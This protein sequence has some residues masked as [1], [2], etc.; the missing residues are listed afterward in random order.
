VFPFLSNTRFA[1]DVYDFTR[2]WT[3]LNIGEITFALGATVNPPADGFSASLLRRIGLEEYFDI[4][5]DER[6]AEIPFE[7]QL[8]IF[9]MHLD[10]GKKY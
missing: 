7:N 10:V 6:F 4:P 2:A 8:G 5:A 3:Q 1:G 9:V